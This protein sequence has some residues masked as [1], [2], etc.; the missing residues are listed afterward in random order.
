VPLRLDKAALRA[1]TVP[2]LLR[3]LVRSGPDRPLTTRR[4]P[5]V[6]TREALLD[7]VREL[8]ATVLGLDSPADVPVG[9]GFLELGFD[10]LLAVE[11]RNAL[12]AATGVRLP[13]T[14]VFDHPT[15]D[16][17]AGY[18]LSRLGGQTAADAALAALDAALHAA[19]EGDRAGILA[20]LRALTEQSTR[21]E[22]RDLDDA[23]DDE[24]F[25][26]IDNEFGAA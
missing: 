9:R 2:A 13:I 24:L 20:R 19:A 4:G 14:L 10:S 3:G 22:H 15:A 16:A 17:A 25:D 11:F 26:L 23:S 7:L 12:A 6:V 8:A 18:L 21:V 5:L 1:R